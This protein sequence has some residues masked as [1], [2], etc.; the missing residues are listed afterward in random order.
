MSLREVEEVIL[1]C[2]QELDDWSGHDSDRGTYKW[3]ESVLLELLS[4]YFGLESKRQKWCKET[5][6]PISK[7]NG[8]TFDIVRKEV[9][10]YEV[11]LRDPIKRNLYYFQ[12]ES[13]MGQLVDEDGKMREIWRHLYGSD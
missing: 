5:N 13:S 11:E 10:S 8:N 4:S 2:I 12:Q 6:K 7:K 1:S 3:I 9:N